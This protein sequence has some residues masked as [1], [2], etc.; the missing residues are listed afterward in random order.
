M[1]T[2]EK[3][4]LLFIRLFKDEDVYDS[5]KQAL[6]KHNVKTGVFL[7]GIGQLSEFELGFFKEKGDYREEKITVPHE[8]LSLSGN[9]SKE[10]FHLHA[11]L[12][13]KDKIAI[14]GHFISGIVSVTAEIIILKTDIEVKRE[15]EEWNGLKGMFLE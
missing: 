13:G 2:K 5:L 11:V 12:S 9:V 4:N 6:K 3:D 7:S 8:L 15:I 10:D 14:G 1:Q